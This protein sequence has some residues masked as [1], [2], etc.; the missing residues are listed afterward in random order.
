MKLAG[1]GSEVGKIL[2]S[3]M[4]LLRSQNRV[5][6]A[7]EGVDAAAGVYNRALEGAVAA[8]PGKVPTSS[9]IIDQATRT[10]KQDPTVLS[11]DVYDP[12]DIL[13]GVGTGAF[14]RRQAQY[15]VD[16]GQQAALLAAAKQG[17]NRDVLRLGGLGLAGGGAYYAY[18]KGRQPQHMQHFS[19][20]RFTR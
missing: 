1:I 10:F 17:R 9:N 4:R 18:D 12:G 15:G 14:G 16:L 7:R 5:R 8:N 19:Q 6:Q 2:T 3:P 20:G 13:R 11:R